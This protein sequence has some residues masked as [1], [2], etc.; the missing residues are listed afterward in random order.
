MPFEYSVK[1]PR[2]RM[3]KVAKTRSIR[4]RYPWADIEPGEGFEFA[5]TVKIMSA[6]VMCAN[7]GNDLGRIFRCYRGVDEKLYAIRMDGMH[8]ELPRADAHSSAPRVTLDTAPEPA[9]VYGNFGKQNGRPMPDNA[10]NIAEPPPAGAPT[11]A[12]DWLPVRVKSESE[13]KTELI[14]RERDRVLA[15]K[16]ESD[17]I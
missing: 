7:N 14:N 9:E 13:L 16:G 12:K 3:P 8:Q 15:E 1:I 5:P 17:P 11:S 2:E 10:K 6:R 4:Y